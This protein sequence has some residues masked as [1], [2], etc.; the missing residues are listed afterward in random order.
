MIGAI[1]RV[2][3]VQALVQR[4]IGG[5]FV[6]AL[7]GLPEPPTV[8]PHVPVAEL[9]DERR[10][11]PARRQH[12]VCLSAR[13]ATVTVSCSAASAQRSI[14]GRSASGTSLE[15]STSSSFAYMTKN[16]VGV[17]VR[18]MNPAATSRTRSTDMRFC[19]SGACRHDRYQRSGRRR[20]GRRPRTDR[21]CCP[22]IST[23][24]C[25]PCRRCGEADAVPVGDAVRHQDRDGVQRV[26]PAARLIDRL[27]E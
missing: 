7:G 13:V 4:Q 20:H 1:S 15:I 12:V 10:Y 14:S 21:R 16:R 2:H 23:S 19:A 24:S 5:L 25:R 18:M 17:P 26:E 27:A 9:I 8:A 11:R 6:A 3:G 22:A